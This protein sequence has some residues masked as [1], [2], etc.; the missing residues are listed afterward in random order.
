MDFFWNAVW[1][2]I[3]TIVLGAGFM[4]LIKGIL[5]ADRNERKMRADVEAEERARLGI[6]P[7]A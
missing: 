3:P 5:G 1:S 7:Q 4:L 2:L 6:P